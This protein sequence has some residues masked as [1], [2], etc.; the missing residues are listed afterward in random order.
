MSALH[1][2]EKHLTKE[3]KREVCCA[4]QCW[5]IQFVRVVKAWWL[6]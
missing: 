5:R 1:A 4:S 6:E 2:V 3:G